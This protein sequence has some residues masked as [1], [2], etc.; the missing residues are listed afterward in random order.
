ML[1]DLIAVLDTLKS[2][3]EQH[4][5][6]L[7]S[8]ETRTRMALIDPLLTVLGWDTSDPGLVTPEYNLSGERADYALLGTV[9]KASA[10]VEAKKLGES[11]A[12]HRMQM[13]NYANM[14]GVAYA[15]LTDGDRWELYTVFDQKPLSERLILDIS[16]ANSPAYQCAL[17]LLLLWRPNL[18]SS[19]LTQANKPILGPTEVLPPAPPAPKSPVQVEPGDPPVPPPPGWT[20][21]ADLQIEPG[22]DAPSAVQFPN[23]E[24]RQIRYWNGI[25]FEVADWLA[26]N[27]HVGAQNCPIARTPAG[28]FYLVHTQAIHPNGK[29]FFNGKKLSNG[30]F[31]ETSLSAKNSSLASRHL[32]QSLGQD[33]SSVLVRVD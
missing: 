1:D 30:L 28:S 2:R 9:G 22:S 27:G 10:F 12:S 3:I 25:V 4:R 20:S 26:R 7:Q 23:G 15:G 13:V 8:N 21:L 32:M 31:V 14:S 17:K 11:L 24:E 19:Q 18:Q 6:D 33:P 16:I 5:A 29:A